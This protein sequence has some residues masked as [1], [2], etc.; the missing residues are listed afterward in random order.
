MRTFMEQLAFHCT[1][2]LLPPQD[3]QQQEL[4][5]KR[6]QLE[7]EIKKTMGWQFADEY[8]RAFYASTNWEVTASFQEGV[9]F[10]LRLAVATLIEE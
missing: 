10:G 7:Q 1:E 5:R 8:I 9:R 3:Q 6:E 4:D 2:R